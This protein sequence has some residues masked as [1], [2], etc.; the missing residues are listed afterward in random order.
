V[1]EIDLLPSR[2]ARGARRL[3]VDAGRAH[4]VDEDGVEARVTRLDRPPADALFY[5]AE[6]AETILLETLP[7]SPA[8]VWLPEGSFLS[9]FIART[10]F[11]LRGVKD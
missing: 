7:T 4:A 8:W 9:E 5:R 6:F 10:I 11:H 2:A 1:E 3:A